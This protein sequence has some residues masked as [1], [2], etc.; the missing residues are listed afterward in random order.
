MLCMRRRYNIGQVAI[1]IGDL[2]LAY[3]CFKVA[4]S[5]DPSH[6]E[7]YNNLGVLDYR[8]GNDDAAKTS[9]K[10]GQRVG[11][12]VFELHYNGALLAFKNGDFQ[13]SFNLAKAALEVYPEHTESQ[14]LM[15]QLK[16]HFSTL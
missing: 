12:H 7:S 16:N 1:G 11:E 6:A 10:M 5:V 2:G 15:K 4:V 14:E 3:Q 9:F 8:K 13:D